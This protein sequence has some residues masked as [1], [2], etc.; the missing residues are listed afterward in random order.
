MTIQDEKQLSARQIKAIPFLIGART[1][2]AGCKMAGI[3]KNTFY[4]WSVNPVFADAM[5][6]AQNAVIDDGLK[7][8]QESMTKA[9]T[10]LTK[11]LSVKSKTLKRLVCNDVISYGLKAKE[12]SEIEARLTALEKTLAERK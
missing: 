8:I 1:V 3:S 11:L 10:E 5:R 4:K 12:L 9:A 2:E 6:K 7:I